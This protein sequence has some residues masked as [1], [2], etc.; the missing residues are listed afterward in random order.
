[1][2]KIEVNLDFLS[3]SRAHPQRENHIPCLGQTPHIPLPRGRGL[4]CS[5]L[6]ESCS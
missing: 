1:M 4:S 5:M 6:T 3:G 2:A